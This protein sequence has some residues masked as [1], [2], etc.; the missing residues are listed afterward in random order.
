LALEKAERDVW[1]GKGRG[2]FGLEGRER[3]FWEWRAWVRRFWE[4]E[5]GWVLVRKDETGP[6]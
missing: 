4:W 3:G 1:E 5:W 6:I 2:A